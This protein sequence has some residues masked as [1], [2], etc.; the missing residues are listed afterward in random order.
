MKT[1]HKF[2]KFQFNSSESIK[3]TTKKR[4][5]VQ[6]VAHVTIRCLY[7]PT[8]PSLL[9]HYAKQCNSAQFFANLEHSCAS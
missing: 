9:R 5:A 4:L 6:F 2:V 7:Y 1:K 8:L 3:R